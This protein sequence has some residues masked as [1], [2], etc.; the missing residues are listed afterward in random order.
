[1]RSGPCFR[2]ERPSEAARSSSSVISDCVNGPHAPLYS[3]AVFPEHQNQ[4]ELEVHRPPDVR[5]PQEVGYSSSWATSSYPRVEVDPVLLSSPPI[6]PEHWDR[7]VFEIPHP[8]HVW[9]LPEVVC[10]AS[11]VISSYLR[12]VP[13]HRDQTES[14][15]PRFPDVRCPQEVGCSSSLAI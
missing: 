15:V 5:C 2:T 13:G 11:L 8:P 6:L 3:S 4:T 14:E 12:V 10:S 1:M 7:S 9:C